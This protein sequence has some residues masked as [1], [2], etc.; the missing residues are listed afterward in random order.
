LFDKFWQILGELVGKLLLRLWSYV[1]GMQP[2]YNPESQ[3]L[4]G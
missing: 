4:L 2:A 1:S 3:L